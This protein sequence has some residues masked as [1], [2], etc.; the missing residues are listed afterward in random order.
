MR[1]RLVLLFVTLFHGSIFAQID[2]LGGMGRERGLNRGNNRLGPVVQDTSSERGRKPAKPKTYPLALYRFY[3]P[4]GDT[5]VLDTLLDPADFHR[6]NFT[7]RDT[8][9]LMPF[10]NIGQPLNRLVWNDTAATASGSP[11]PE[12]MR[13]SVRTAGELHYH[14]VP[15]PFTRLFFLSGNKKGQMLDSRIG[16]NIRPNWNMGLGYKGLNSLGYYLHSL[17]SQENWFFNTDYAAPSGRFFLR[18]YLV[19]NH[20]ENDENNGIADERYFEQG[21]DAYIDRGKIPVRTTDDQS[22]WHSRQSGGEAGWAPLKKT[23]ALKLTYGLDEYKAYFE[24]KGGAAVYGSTLTY[25][26]A[27]D[28]TGYRRFVHRLG[29]RWNRARSHWQAG[30][31]MQRM[32]VRYDTTITAGNTM[33]PRST[34]L[35]DR[36]IFASYR[37]RDSLLRWQVGGKL[38]TNGLYAFEAHGAYALGKHRFSAGITLRNQRPAPVYWSHQSRFVRYNWHSSPMTENYRQ[39]RLQWQ[40]PLG[41]LSSAYG[42]IQNLSYFGADSLPRV[43]P[44]TITIWW[45]T[46]RK[47]WRIKKWGFFPEITYQTV[48]NGGPALDLPKWRARATLYYTDWW[49]THHLYLNTGIRLAWFSDYYMPGYLPLT[50]SFFQQRSKRYGNF[51]LADLFF[52]FKV[53]KFYAYLVLEHFNAYWEKYHPRYY[54]APYYP[55]A[56]QVIRLGI[57]WEFTN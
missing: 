8:Y 18:F 22:I 36:G 26:L 37:H 30:M 14:H 3:T 43:Y 49:F 17:T 55:Y 42:Q 2:R 40:S 27:Y 23:P 46:Y 13:A 15:T 45:A 33:V 31:L 10:Q 41:Q 11:V 4:E 38:Y 29:I 21:G 50:G 35:T 48:S 39:I 24:Y 25:P 44:N 34:L 9:N 32:F 51:Y 57:V 1:F 5:L 7:G 6:A 12:G 56:D 20:L 52:N 54:S 28:S 19:K 16:M 47:D 53:K